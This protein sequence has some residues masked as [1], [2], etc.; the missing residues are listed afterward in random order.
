MLYS[1]ISSVSILLY[2]KPVNLPAKTTLYFLI[3]YPIAVEQQMIIKTYR[4]ELREFINNN[5]DLILTGVKVDFPQ[6]I[7]AVTLDG[8]PVEAQLEN[9]SSGIYHGNR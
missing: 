1:L 7:W 2:L 6:N 8:S 4:Q 3:D 9:A 5:K